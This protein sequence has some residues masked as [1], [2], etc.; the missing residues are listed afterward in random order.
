MLRIFWTCGGDLGELT[1]L[2]PKLTMGDQAGNHLI[3]LCFVPGFSHPP[4]A[5]GAMIPSRPKSVAVLRT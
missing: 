4:T 5:L 1:Y 2:V 3:C